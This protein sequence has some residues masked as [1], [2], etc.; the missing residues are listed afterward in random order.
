MPEGEAFQKQKDSFIPS[1]KGGTM[2]SKVNVLV[3]GPFTDCVLLETQI[4]YLCQYKVLVL[5]LISNN[6]F[7]VPSFCSAQSKYWGALP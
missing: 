7:V 6:I 5:A 2:G 4:L 3:K 1:V